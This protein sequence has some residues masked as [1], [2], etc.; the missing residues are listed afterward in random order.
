MT[1]QRSTGPTPRHT[2]IDSLRDWLS[3]PARDKAIDLGVALLVATSIAVAVLVWRTAVAPPYTIRVS[4]PTVT[5]TTTVT[6]APPAPTPAAP[7]TKK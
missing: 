7:P 4:M 6:V 2:L 5:A 1:G 3:Q